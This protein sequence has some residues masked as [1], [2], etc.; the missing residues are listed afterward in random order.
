MS[1]A[2]ANAF[3]ASVSVADAE[4]SSLFFVVGRIDA[5]DRAVREAGGRV[6][7]RLPDPRRV[8]AVM[9]MSAYPGITRH[10][11]LVSAGPVNIDPGRFG[12]FARL[13]GLDDESGHV[14][15]RPP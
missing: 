12:A 5:P 15:R 14:A 13:V 1:S 3:G 11:D 8:L 7:T 10:R 9:P 6:V 2:I 4:G